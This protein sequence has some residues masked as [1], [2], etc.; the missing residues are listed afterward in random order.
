MFTEQ[1]IGTSL[2]TLETWKHWR[3]RLEIK[4]QA[5]PLKALKTLNKT[6]YRKGQE[7]SDRMLKEYVTVFQY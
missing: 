5:K 4:A 7:A 6:G 2:K 1:P 3:S